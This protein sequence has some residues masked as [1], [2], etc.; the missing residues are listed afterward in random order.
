MNQPFF[1]YLLSDDKE[2]SGQLSEAVSHDR[3][4]EIVSSQNLNTLS[5]RLRQHESLQN[6]GVFLDAKYAS[7]SEKL[8]SEQIKKDVLFVFIQ[9]DSETNLYDTKMRAENVHRLNV[10]NTDHLITL[11]ELIKSRSIYNRSNGPQIISTTDLVN[12]EL[13]SSELMQPRLLTTSTT[14]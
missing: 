10:G 1:I 6:A 11:L 7:E 5:Q 13:L 14:Y 4:A 12:Q 3:K 9:S 2:F 8:F